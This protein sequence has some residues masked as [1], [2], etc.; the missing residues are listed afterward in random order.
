MTEAGVR[1][2]S[3]CMKKKEGDKGCQMLYTLLRTNPFLL[4][5]I[6]FLERGIS[7]F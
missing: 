6:Q 3:R 7:P 1:M 4:E 5:I 2:V